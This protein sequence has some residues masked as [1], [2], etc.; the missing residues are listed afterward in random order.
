ME[1]KHTLC[2][3]TIKNREI[4][5]PAGVPRLSQTMVALLAC[6]RIRRKHY[7]ALRFVVHARMAWAAPAERLEGGSG[8]GALGDE[9]GGGVE[10]EGDARGPNHR[11][12]G[13]EGEGDEEGQDERS[14]AATSSSRGAGMLPALESML[15]SVRRAGMSEGGVGDGGTKARPCDGS[16]A[17]LVSEDRGGAHSKRAD[18]LERIVEVIGGGDV[19][20]GV[21][22]NWRSKA[23]G[24]LMRTVDGTAEQEARRTAPISREASVRTAFP[25]VPSR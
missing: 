13:G 1:S 19:V 2:C 7:A 4:F 16:F 6:L 9:D 25:D 8:G 14:H 17:A 21:G 22:V 15:P 18:G 23:G 3:S 24:D 20:F 11:G 12:E 5:V 10:E